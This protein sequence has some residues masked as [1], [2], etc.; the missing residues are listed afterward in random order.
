MRI[1]SYSIEICLSNAGSFCQNLCYTACTFDYIGANEPVYFFQSFDI[2]N[3]LYFDDFRYTIVLNTKCDS[4]KVPE[5]LRSLFAYIN[6]PE[7]VDDEFIQAIEE[8]VQKFNSREWRNK[9]MTL[10]HLME[11]AEERGRKEGFDAG[12]K[13]G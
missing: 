1:L 7:R 13:K 11:N 8:R 10:A 3:G 4:S 6:D 12:R 2:K 5:K 9:Q